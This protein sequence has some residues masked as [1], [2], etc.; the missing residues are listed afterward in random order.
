MSGLVS[1]CGVL[2]AALIALLGTPP[3]AAAEKPGRPDLVLKGDAVCTRCHGEGGE[4]PVLAIGRTPHGTRA[5][6]RTPTCSSCH[7]V[8]ETHVRKPAEARERPKPEVIAARLKG[9]EQSGEAG[10]RDQGES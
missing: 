3:V 6:A 10:E 1:R 7:G 8:S 5:D 4:F 9:D 2:A